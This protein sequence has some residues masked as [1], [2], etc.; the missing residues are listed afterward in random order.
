MTSSRCHRLASMFILVLLFGLLPPVNGAAQSQAQ[1]PLLVGVLDLEANDVSATEARSITDRLRIYLNRSQVFEVLE[2]SQMEGILKEQGFQ[3]SG[4]CDTDECVV[5]VGRILGARKMVAGSVAKVGNV[6]SI[7]VRIVDIQTSR[8]EQTA[9]ADT[10]GNIGNVLQE[11]T[12]QAALQLIRAVRTSLGLPP[13]EDLL[14]E[15]A[16][17]R[18]VTG[19][20]R[21]PNGWHLRWNA[22]A[23]SYNVSTDDGYDADLNGSGVAQDVMVGVAVSDRFSI[24]MVFSAILSIGLDLDYGDRI[25]HPASDTSMTLLGGMVGFAYYLVPRSWYVTLLVGSSG[26]NLREQVEDPSDTSGSGTTYQTIANGGVGFGL[27]LT[28]GKEWW[29]SRKVGFGMALKGARYT[30]ATLYGMQFTFLW[31]F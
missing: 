9:F 20:V 15:E 17:L 24:L 13:S 10:R 27:Q 3:L 31:D 16:Q 25:T 11:G 4:A 26:W 28:L 29:I 5:Q 7:M 22:G 18:G 12:L 30:R 1:L 14:G 6:Y 23:G 2:R 8:I 19:P 21:Y